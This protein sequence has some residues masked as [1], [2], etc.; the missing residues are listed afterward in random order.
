VSAR[1]I[2]LYLNKYEADN[3][4]Q[5][6]QTVN[7]ILKA[8]GIQFQNSLA[9]LKKDFQL[10]NMEPP[11]SAIAQVTQLL[12]TIGPEER[13]I[14]ECAAFI[15]TEFNATTLSNA[16]NEERLNVLAS[17]RELESNGLIADVLD[18]DDVYR[19]SSSMILNGLRYVTSNAQAGSSDN[20]SQI[21]REYHFRVAKAIEKQFNVSADKVP[22]TST[23]DDH[24]LYRLAKRAKAAGEQMAARALHYNIAAQTRATKSS[25]YH[26]SILF[27]RNAL[28]SAEKL[29]VSS[30]QSSMIESI[31][32][33]MRG[34]IYTNT[35][36]TRIKSF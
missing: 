9:F 13:R 16:L 3:I 34:M 6:I 24:T 5:V 33:T 31:F 18:Q 35:N 36:P 27:G 2:A 4:A 19:F 23:I 32:S 8:D 20:M 25:Q 21:V 14:L 26:N 1:K 10:E 22:D 7:Q 15:G 28:V 12:K 11:S 17:L 29:D 30:L